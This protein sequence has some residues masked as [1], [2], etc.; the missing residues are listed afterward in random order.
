MSHSWLYSCRA[1]DYPG[2]FV[3]VF[4]GAVYEISFMVHTPSERMMG[5]VQFAFKKTFEALHASY[6]AFAWMESVND[7][8]IIN[9]Y[10]AAP[11]AIGAPL[12]FGIPRPKN[13][14]RRLLKNPFTESKKKL[15][16][17]LR[18]EMRKHALDLLQSQ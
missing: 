11:C 18:A 9:A 3:P 10:L 1:E 4:R 14:Y 16:A 17:Y 13:P 6:P 12:V 15:K 2:Y 5:Y 7:E 8:A